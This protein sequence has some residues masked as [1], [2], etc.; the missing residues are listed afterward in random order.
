MFNQFV[1]KF[2]YCLLQTIEVN[3]AQKPM[4]KLPLKGTY[5][6]HYSLFQ[7]EVATHL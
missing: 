4:S 2:L 7:I 5:K 6:L 3:Q 1:V